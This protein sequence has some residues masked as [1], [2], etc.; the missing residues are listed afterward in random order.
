MGAERQEHEQQQDV[1]PAHFRGKPP[2]EEESVML[3]VMILEPGDH[4]HLAKLLQDHPQMREQIIEKATEYAGSDTVGKA[5]AMLAG[6]VEKS[7]APENAGVAADA[8][9]PTGDELMKPDFDAGSTER[10]PSDGGGDELMTPD[11]EAKTPEPDNAEKPKLDDDLIDPYANDAAPAQAA[12]EPAKEEAKED[13]D[14]TKYFILEFNSDEEKVNELVAYIKQH[15]AHREKVLAGVLEWDP[16]LFDG[17][18]RGLA[19]PAPEAEPAPCVTPAEIKEEPTSA[20]QKVE[21]KAESGWV[22]RAKEYNRCHPGLV[23]KFNQL[24]LYVCFS[25]TEPDV[26]PVK[27]ADWQQAHGVPPDGRV[28]PQTVAAAEKQEEPAPA[29][30]PAPVTAADPTA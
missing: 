27:V 18:M 29:A 15:P 30:E 3:L 4:K 5:L 17:V 22:T 24:T 23:D 28:G 13:F 26:D 8:G 2:S 7:G 21:K 14:Y 6:A 20:E 11:F 25:E 19:A 12:A 10:K 16:H 9:A 1:D